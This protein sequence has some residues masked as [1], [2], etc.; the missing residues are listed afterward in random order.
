MLPGRRALRG[1]A[2]RSVFL[3]YLPRCIA[4]QGWQRLAGW[5]VLAT[6]RGR[7]DPKIGCTGNIKLEGAKNMRNNPAFARKGNWVAWRVFSISNSN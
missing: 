4:K 6:G 7:N 2:T 3:P 1:A 5:V